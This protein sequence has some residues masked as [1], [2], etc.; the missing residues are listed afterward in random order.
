MGI[1]MGRRLASFLFKVLG[2]SLSRDLDFWKG[3]YALMTTSK[4]SSSIN[5]RNC[6]RF[7]NCEAWRAW[8]FG[9]CEP[10]WFDA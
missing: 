6:L 4:G 8:R 9:Q 3:L 1:Q 7:L 5:C 10:I 2:T